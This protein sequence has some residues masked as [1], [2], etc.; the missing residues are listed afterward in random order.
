MDD[1][2]F[3]RFVR[4]TQDGAVRF[5]QGYLGDWDEARDAAQEAFVRAH[6]KLPTLRSGEALKGWFFRLLAN[7]LRDRLRRRKLRDFWGR[8]FGEGEVREEALG[9]SRAGPEE[10]A[11]SAALR[12]SIIKAVGRLPGRQREVFSMKSLAGLTFSEI[13]GVL[14]ISEGAAKTHYSRA[15][16]VLREDLRHWRDE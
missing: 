14:S 12:E 2:T 15:L 5:A 6:E 13:S 8:L 10:E 11:I 1:L 4:D 16:T 7:H 9:D 3:E